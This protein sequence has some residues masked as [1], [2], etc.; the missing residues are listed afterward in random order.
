MKK[1]KV[2]VA[3]DEKNVAMAIKTI[4]RKHFNCRLV[5]VAENGQVAWNMIIA[6]E[7][8]LII[9]DWNMP[10]KSG[11]ELL[12]D[13]RSNDKTRD[14]PFLMLTARSDKDSFIKAL[15]AGVSD[16][17]V[18]PFKSSALIEKLDKLLQKRFP[19]TP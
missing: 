2:L 16:Y 12:L 18:K 8:D 4:V 1:I 15:Q 19:S 13:V 5:D 9:A 17:L 14:I 11:D 3:E 10:R 6:G 7:Y